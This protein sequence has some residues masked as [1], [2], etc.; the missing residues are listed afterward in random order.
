MPPKGT[1]TLPMPAT[2]AIKFIGVICA[3]KGHCDTVTDNINGIIN[4]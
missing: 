1:A 3:T 4:L 2:V